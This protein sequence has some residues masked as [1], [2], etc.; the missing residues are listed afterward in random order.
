MASKAS[1]IPVNEKTDLPLPETWTERPVLELCDGT[2][3][4]PGLTLIA[5]GRKPIRTFFSPRASMVQRNQ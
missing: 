1:S 5:T 2:I 3:A 4:S